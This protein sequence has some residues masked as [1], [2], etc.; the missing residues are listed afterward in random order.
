MAWFPV[1]GSS[2]QNSSIYNSPKR[3]A[4]DLVEEAFE[5]PV[6]RGLLCLE[7][8]AGDETLEGLKGETS[9]HPDLLV[10]KEA[11]A[12]QVPLPQAVEQLLLHQ[13]SNNSGDLLA[14]ALEAEGPRAGRVLLQ[15]GYQGNVP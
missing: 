15:G 13:V 3:R 7:L 1:Y 2:Y 11:V 6:L 12:D 14:V 9:E 8:K 5:L 4:Q 10:Q